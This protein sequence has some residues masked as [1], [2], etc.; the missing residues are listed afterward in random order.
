MSPPPKE[1]ASGVVDQPEVPTQANAIRPAPK[2]TGI[3]FREVCTDSVNGRYDIVPDEVLSLVPNIVYIKQKYDVTAL[4][5]AE[6]ALWMF[7]K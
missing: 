1:K 7:G 6:G 2:Q 3:V 5:T 4:L